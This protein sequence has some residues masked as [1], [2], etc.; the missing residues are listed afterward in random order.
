MT[1]SC[2]DL[3][4]SSQIEVDRIVKRGKLC[5]ATT[6]CRREIERER[7]LSD[8]I[9]DAGIAL[10]VNLNAVSWNYLFIQLCLIACLIIIIVI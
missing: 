5:C 4:A 10:L 6:L 8:L 1:T 9:S 3:S 2:I 7:E